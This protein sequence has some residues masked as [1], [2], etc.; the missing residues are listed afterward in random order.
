MTFRKSDIVVKNIVSTSRGD[1]PFAVTARIVELLRIPFP[2][3]I[4]GHGLTTDFAYVKRL[5]FEGFNGRQD[6][7][8]VAI[9]MEP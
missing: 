6:E 4:A 1:P 2:P 8:V 9:R 7:V 5:E 3:A